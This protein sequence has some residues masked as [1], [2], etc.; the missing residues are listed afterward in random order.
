MSAMTGQNSR[1]KETTAIRERLEIPEKYTW[2][3]EDLFET[4]EDWEKAF[5]RAG[6][7]GKDL[8][9]RKGSL[10]GS[11]EGLLEALR[12]ADTLEELVDRVVVYA[13]L[14][15]HQ[16][17]RDSSAQAMA[18]RSISLAVKTGE[19]TSFVVP[20]IIEAGWDRVAEFLAEREGLGTYRFLLEDV[21][22]QSGHRLSVEGETL[23]SGAVEIG[24]APENVFS[25][26][27]NADM[28]FPEV[29]DGK[30]RS[31]PLSQE[32][33]GMYLVSRDRKLRENAFKTLHETYGSFKNTLSGTLNAALRSAAYFARSRK[34]DSTLEAAL[35]PDNI[36]VEVYHGLIGTVGKHLHLLHR[37]VEAK[38]QALG[39]DSLHMYDMY[40]PLAPEPRTDVPYEDA[41][42][43]IDGALSPLGE[44]YLSLL[45]Q[46]FGGRWIDVLENRGKRGG[47][48]SWGSYGV[49]PYVLLNYNG[50]FRDIFTIAHEMGHA[51]HKVCTDRE[52][53][54][55]YSGH[56]IFTAEVASITNEI[57]LHK[58]LQEKASSP[59]EKVYFAQLLLEQIRTTFFRQTLFAEFE[60]AVHDMVAEGE[61]PTAETFSALWRDLNV[62]YYGSRL[63][64][65]RELEY[66]WAR[67][68]HFYSPF[69]VYQYATGYAAATSLSGNITGG[70][71]G[72]VRRYMEFL[73]SGKS[74][75]PVEL[76]RRAGVD[77]TSTGPVEAVATLFENTLEDLEAALRE[78]HDT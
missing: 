9:L 54:Y 5:K 68:P 16:D 30:G 47:A 50:T 28:S 42:S 58:D 53:P 38:K 45:R 10:K 70:G 22:R 4:T 23:L 52:Q 36:P 77:M 76:L 73:G 57:L 69:Y 66:E 2:R 71:Q 65:D 46:G 33:L 72:A 8:A 14:L 7:L 12:L 75:Y 37:Y 39:L 6:A 27:T 51:L 78:T 35:S 31:H 48:Y 25:M 59:L 34:Y 26:L 63:V 15:S 64:I 49:H 21:F 55:A 24:H 44:E 19:L 74:D 62:K 60:L 61:A 3:L 29:T 40:F 43:I 56:S 17:T 20:E 13:H 41:C 32:R 1:D 11:P 18:A 67:I